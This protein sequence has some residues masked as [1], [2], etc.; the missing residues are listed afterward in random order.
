MKNKKGLS[1][2]ISTLL[3][4][5]L[6]MVITAIV[7]AF[8]NST[9]KEKTSQASSCFNLFDKVVL[10]NDYTCYNLSSNIVE[11]SIGIADLDVDG[12]VVGISSSSGSKSF[13]ITNTAQTIQGLANYPD[14]STNIILP[15]KNAGLTYIASGFSTEPDS[16]KIAPIVS[17]QQCDVTDTISNIAT[18]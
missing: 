9:V 4:L 11:F 16:I 8:V 15:A 14:G 13:T 1:T 6:L 3:I 7:W 10:N 2:V 12:V 18:C 5:M 17:G